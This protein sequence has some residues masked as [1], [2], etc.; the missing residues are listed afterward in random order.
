M[1]PVNQKLLGFDPSLPAFAAGCAANKPRLATT[2][3]YHRARKFLF[4]LYALVSK[5][6][7]IQTVILCEDA[8]E[9]IT[10]KVEGKYLIDYGYGKQTFF[11]QENRESS[12]QIPTT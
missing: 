11:I 7:N 5:C 2:S 9:D 6:A 3:R 1:L 12:V 4:L 8:L 10:H